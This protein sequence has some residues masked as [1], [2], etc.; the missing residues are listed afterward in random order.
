MRK[1]LEQRGV[2]SG[3]RG[4]SSWPWMPERNGGNVELSGHRLIDVAVIEGGIGGHMDGE[5][6]KSHHGA[7]IERAVTGDIGFIERQGVL[8]Q[9]DVAV[10][11]IGSGCDAKAIAK[12]ASFLTMEEPLGCTWLVLFLTPSRQSGSPLGM[13]VTSKVPLT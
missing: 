7:Q 5:V 3:S 8:G 11:R 1:P 9:H 2:P 6:V 4:T 13:W 10:V 12:Q